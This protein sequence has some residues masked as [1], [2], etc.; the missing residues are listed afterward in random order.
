MMSDYALL[1]QR[2]LTL[3]AQGFTAPNP[4]VGCVLEREGT[5]VGE[6]YHHRAGMPHAEVEAL[7]SAGDRAK[8][9][10]AIVTLEPCSHWGRTPPCADA[11]IEAG[12][13]RVVVAMEDPDPRVRGQGLARLRD[14]GIDVICGVEEQAARHLNRAFIHYHTTGTPWLTVKLAVSLDGRIATRTGQSQWITGDAARQTVHELRA[15]HDAV[16]VGRNTVE[17]DDPELTAR[18]ERIPSDLRRTRIVLDS[19]LSLPEGLRIWDTR[20][21][22]TIVCTTDS[23]SAQRACALEALGVDVCLARRR[24]D[25]RVDLASMLQRLGERGITSILVEGGGELIGAL[26][27]ARLAHEMVVFIAPRVIGGSGARPAVAGL[28][29]ANLEDA[30]WLEQVTWQSCGVDMMAQGLLVWRQEGS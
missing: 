26:L 23:A 1:M 5:V 22:P 9:A 12:I 7:R 19:R 30:P 28:G 10:T 15:R 6:G 16:M 27:D 25:G 17:A 3:A 4:M 29:A 21:A 20:L 11:L 13:S 2:A 18:G 24:P 8:G 14:A